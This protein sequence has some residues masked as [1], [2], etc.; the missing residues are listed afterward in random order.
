MADTI[1][2]ARRSWNMS[3]IKGRDTKPE[4]QIRSMLH[5]MGLR[6][7]LHRAEL[8]G[9]P[10]I[11]LVGRRTVVFVHGCFWHRHGR[12]R[13]AYSPKSRKAYWSRK[14]AKNVE[15]DQAQRK[16]LQASGWKTVVVWEC[17]LR[18]EA[19]ITR[20]LRRLFDR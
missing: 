18:D 10:D 8:P 6:F 7:R 16:S 1:S 17:E 2:P 4:I 5:R 13:F 19:R 9:K 12:C 15:R 20:R 3:R 14:F 11:V